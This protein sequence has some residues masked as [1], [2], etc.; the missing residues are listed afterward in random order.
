MINR[1]KLPNRSESLDIFDYEIV[2]IYAKTLKMHQVA[3]VL[4]CR[5]S[6]KVQGSPVVACADK[7]NFDVVTFAFIS[8]DHPTEH[9][10][11]HST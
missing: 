3:N 10:V 5:A 6:M 9:A 1:K 7:P 2:R 4:A 11:V 8:T